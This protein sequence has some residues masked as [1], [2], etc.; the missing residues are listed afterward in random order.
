M[1]LTLYLTHVSFYSGTNKCWD[2]FGFFVHFIVAIIVFILLP[3]ANIILI[4]I[5]L[6]DSYD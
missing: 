6:S 3:I 2:S 4:S 5:D 1:V